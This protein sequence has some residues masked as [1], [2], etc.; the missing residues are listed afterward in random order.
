MT[1]ICK[2]CGAPVESRF[3]S[4]CG[5][6]ASTHRISPHFLWH[7]IQHGILHVDKGILFTAKELFT[8]PGHSIR[9]FLQGKR[10]KHFK[11]ISLVIILAGIYGFLSH[12]FHI[13][14]LSNNIKISGS[15]E[16]FDKMKKI[17]SSSSEWLSSHY[18]IFSLLQ[19]PVLAI[20]TWLF[21]KRAG[22]NFIEHIV[23]HSFLTGQR[24]IIRIITFPL[25][26]AYNE[27]GTLRTIARITDMIAF[28]IAF[29]SLYQ[30]F[31]NIPWWQRIIR[32]AGSFIISFS[33]MLVVIYILFKQLL[34][35]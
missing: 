16:Q 1:H 18:S 8:R 23:I 9:E 35:L 32:T 3:C 24:L 2:N 14:L 26:Y 11:P 22:Y 20:G 30:L 25:F 21:F 29:W 28:S 33:I 19:I 12:Y 31:S 10:V 15:G 17:I 7:D 34:N 5:Q 4:D 6:P 27:T 13:D